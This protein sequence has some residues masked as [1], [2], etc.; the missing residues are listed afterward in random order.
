MEEKEDVIDAFNWVVH[1]AQGDGFF[2]LSILNCA[3]IFRLEC[4]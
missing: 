2:L 4:E 3:Q 1:A